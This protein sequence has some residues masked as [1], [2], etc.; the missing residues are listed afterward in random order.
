MGLDSLCSEDKSVAY[1]HPKDFGQL[2]RKRSDMLDMFLK[3]YEDWANF[4]QPITHFKSN[5]KEGKATHTNNPSSLATQN[6]QKRSLTNA[7]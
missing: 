6:L 1:A 4:D 3:V 5:I 7:P 2:A